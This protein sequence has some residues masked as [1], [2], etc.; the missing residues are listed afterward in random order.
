MQDWH[1]LFSTLFSMWVAELPRRSLGIALLARG[2]GC[3]SFWGRLVLGQEPAQ[4]LQLWGYLCWDKVMSWVLGRNHGMCQI[5]VLFYSQM[6]FP[7]PTPRVFFKYMWK[8]LIWVLFGYILFINS[9]STMHLNTYLWW[10]CL[11]CN[12]VRAKTW[13]KTPDFYIQVSVC[14]CLFWS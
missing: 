7:L 9:V 6:S 4:H 2:M 8:C 13:W 3:L 10:V 14:V 11:I 12:K 1:L 5:L